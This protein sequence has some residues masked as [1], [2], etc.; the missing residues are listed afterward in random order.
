MLLLIFAGWASLWDDP[1]NDA[2]VVAE[3]DFVLNYYTFWFTHPHMSHGK[4]CG[5]LH[6]V[7]LCYVTLSYS[8]NDIGNL[9]CVTNFI[10]GRFHAIRA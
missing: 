8:C 5:T 2:I 1:D 10:N 4:V 7:T 3:G 9:Q 6:Y